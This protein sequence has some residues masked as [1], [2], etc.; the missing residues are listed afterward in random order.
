MTNVN[1][2]PVALGQ[3]VTTAEETAKTITLSGTDAD[4]DTLSFNSVSTPSNGTLS[5][6]AP[7]LTYTPAANFTGSDSFTFKVNDGT[8]DSI[9]TATVTITVTNVND[10]PV[11]LG[12]SVTTAE[13]TAKT[14]TL[15]GTDA[16]SDTL[17]FNSVSTPS[18]GT[19]S[20]TAPNLTYTPAANF[21]GSDSFTFKVNDGTV[22]SI[23]T[24]TVTITVTNVND[25]PVALGQSV[26]TAEET[27]K[28][29]TLS[30][31][32]ADS[33]TL[34]FNSVS[35]PSNGT[36]SGTAP[37]LTYTPA[38]NFTGS[39]SFTFKV[40]DGTVDS[41]QRRQSLSSD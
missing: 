31:T 17:S 15:S 30:G 8:V 28:T 14:I 23:T 26:T 33:D 7:N 41:K 3:S 18:N 4:S 11:A 32:D 40:N 37:N 38:A 1:D 25:V 21:T 13:E 6:T 24:A 5:G 29:I 22:D 16:D 27:A 9:T 10:V 35:T 20:G 12:Q 34:S 36:L 2:A 39:D 19:L